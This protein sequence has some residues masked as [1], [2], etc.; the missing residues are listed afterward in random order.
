MTRFWRLGGAFLFGLT[1]SAFA[2]TPAQA[3]NPPYSGCYAHGV[4]GHTV[5]AYGSGSTAVY[6]G[7]WENYQLLHKQ[8]GRISSCADINT[9][10]NWA[11]AWVRVTFCPNNGTVNGI[12][13]VSF[14]CYSPGWGYLNV[15]GSLN[16]GV[17]AHWYHFPSNSNWNW[18]Y[19]IESQGTSEDFAVYV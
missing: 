2:V 4:G 16:Y 12:P 9:V 1:L 17:A 10:A 7:P 19:R 3:D 18:L 6:A 8:A 15:G 13:P 11:P 5:Y 14:S